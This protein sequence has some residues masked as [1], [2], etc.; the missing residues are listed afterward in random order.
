MFLFCIKILNKIWNNVL[1]GISFNFMS[2]YVDFKDKTLFYLSFDK[3]NKFYLSKF[4]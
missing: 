1:I 4:K 2:P 3:N